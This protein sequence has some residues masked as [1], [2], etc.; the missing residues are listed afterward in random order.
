MIDFFDRKVLKKSFLP[1]EHT[2]KRFIKISLVSIFFCQVQDLFGAFFTRL[3]YYPYS[4]L[5]IYILIAP[6]AFIVYLFLL[7]ILYESIEK[8]VKNNLRLSFNQKNPKLYKIIMNIEFA[9]GITGFLFAFKYLLFLIPQFNIAVI[10]IQRST[11]IEI[12]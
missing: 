11:N 4:S 7:F 12:V 10:D 3:W 9:L 5:P 1:T 8:V 6:I 2:K